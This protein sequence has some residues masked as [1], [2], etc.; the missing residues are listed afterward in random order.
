MGRY[1][2]YISYYEDDV[3]RFM[4]EHKISMATLGG[5]GI[6]GKVALAA[7]C[8]HY[9]KVTGYFGINTTPMDQFYHEG[10]G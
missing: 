5:H 1:G 3:M 4:Y 2:K 8:Y 6:G 9:D 10:Y 7:S